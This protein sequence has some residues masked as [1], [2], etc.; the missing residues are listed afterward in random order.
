MRSAGTRA[1]IVLLTTAV[2]ISKGQT[3]PPQRTINENRVTT[4]RGEKEANG[5]ERQQ[6]APSGQAM[7]SILSS[8]ED[9]NAIRDAYLSRL[10]GDGCSPDVAARVAEL[11]AQ[12][13]EK[14]ESR[15]PGPRAG[16][17]RSAADLQ[18]SMLALAADW[19]N[20]RPVEASALASTASR[21][22]ERAKLLE[23]ALTPRDSAANVPT[24]VDNVHLKLELERLLGTCNPGRR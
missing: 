19:Y 16:T 13:G 15:G 3:P 8:T 10:S 5:Q 12:L 22:A 2:L 6:N 23:A 24:A 9:L 1:F 7:Q 17:Q 20:R 11:R 14:P 18:A 4:T 21:D